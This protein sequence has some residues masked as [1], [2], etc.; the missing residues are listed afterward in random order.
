MSC[1]NI[2]A[3]MDEMIDETGYDAKHSFEDEIIPIEEYYE[4]WQDRIALLGG[5]DVDFLSRATPEQVFE[6]SRAMVER[7]RDRGGYALGSGNSIPDYVP[8]E[9]Y[10]A[11]LK[12]A[13]V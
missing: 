5:I 12:A 4:K 1:G 8:V 6:R 10:H 7:S 9:N 2:E 13:L 3:V 11:M